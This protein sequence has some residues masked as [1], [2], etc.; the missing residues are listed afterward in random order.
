[1]LYIGIGPENGKTVQEEDAFM[2]AMECVTTREKEWNE[3]C[4]NF[5]FTERDLQQFR[6]NVVNWFYSGN[7]TVV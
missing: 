7:W 5:Q 4:K 6:E 3:F 1:M 2:Y